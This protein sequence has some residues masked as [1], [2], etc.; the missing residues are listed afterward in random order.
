MSVGVATNTYG[1]PALPCVAATSLTDIP[2]HFR[3]HATV[4][5]ATKPRRKIHPLRDALL[6]AFCTFA[7]SSIGLA[8][9]YLKARDVQVDAVRTELLQL[10]RATAVQIDGDVHKTLVSPA[11]DGSPEHLALLEPIAR[12]HRAT[13]D[14][15]YTY[16]GIYRDGRI[17]WILDGARLYRVPGNELPADPIMTLYKV[18]DAAYE[19]AFRTGTEYADPQPRPYADGH[20]YLSAAAPIRDHAG[21]VVGMFGLDMVL[22]KLDA[23]L[24]AIRRVLYVALIVVSLL[25]VAAGAI[26]H[27]MRR[28]AAA[29]VQKMRAARAQAEANALAA[30]S[31]NRAKATFLAM[32]SHEIRTPMNGMLGV[33]DLLRAQSPSPEQKRLLDVL[34]SSGESLLRIIND[35]LDFS[36]I[37]A[38]KLELRPRPFEISVLLAEIDALLSTQARAKQ[39][40]FVLDA[41]SALPAVVSG[42]RQ[43]LSQV[44]MNLGNNAVK[45][46]DHGEVRLVVRA[47][48]AAGGNPRVEFTVHDTGIGMSPDSLSRLFT[49]FAQMA[50]GRAH[51]AGAPAWVS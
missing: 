43:R 15:Y 35:I 4:P 37:E 6:A 9:L 50:E 1:A 7:I 27:R 8:I 46:T 44:L 32:M 21:N 18:R 12:M 16:T 36:K 40:R 39:I 23:R 47:L 25:S 48:P 26:A 45:F 13:H 51:S 34:A 22:D 2:S 19:E 11:Q 49:P 31:A 24:A 29:I 5:G 14:I 10:A 3:Q 38:E 17:Y 30:E 33:A 41:D 42:D 20:N 28:F